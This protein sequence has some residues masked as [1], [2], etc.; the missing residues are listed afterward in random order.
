MQKIAIVV[1]SF[2]IFLTACTSGTSVTTIV[3]SSD[4]LRST[5]QSFC[6]K[7]ERESLDFDVLNDL[8][9]LLK[10]K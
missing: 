5:E 7:I 8:M 2:V 4:T 1:V 10:K 6:P 3:N 9:D